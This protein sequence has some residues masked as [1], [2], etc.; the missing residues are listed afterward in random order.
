MIVQ[1][2][3]S[4]STYTPGQSQNHF[5]LR[6]YKLIKCKRFY[7]KEKQK[8]ILGTFDCGVTRIEMFGKLHSAG[9]EYIM[10]KNYD[11][12]LKMFILLS[13]NTEYL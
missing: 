11:F 10:E 9:T 13:Y 2:S 3:I 1:Q 8:T 6:L 12:Q 4:R 7:V 5:S